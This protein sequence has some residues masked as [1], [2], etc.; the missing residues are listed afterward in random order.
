MAQ[1]SATTVIRHIVLDVLQ[2]RHAGQ[3]NVLLGADQLE[4][5][6]WDLSGD[7]GEEANDEER[8]VGG[9]DPLVVA[10]HQQQDENV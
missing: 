10:T 8:V 4:P 3:G 6:Q 9:V 5:D 7:S 1:V 2:Q